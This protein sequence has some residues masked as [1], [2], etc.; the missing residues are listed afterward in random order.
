MCLSPRS[1][2]RQGDKHGV[3]LRN[4]YMEQRLEWAAVISGRGF[5]AEGTRL[6]ATRLMAATEKR[7]MSTFWYRLGRRCSVMCA[8]LPGTKSSTTPCSTTNTESS[9]LSLG[10]GS[11]GPRL[12]QRSV[13]DS[14]PARA[15]D[16]PKHKKHTGLQCNMVPVPSCSVQSP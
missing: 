8:G 7:F 3:S 14:Q 1:I 12:F 15:L 10:L 13:L 2:R 6:I 16:I 11:D 4:L 5:P 9:G